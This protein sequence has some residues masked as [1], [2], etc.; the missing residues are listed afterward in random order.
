MRELTEKQMNKLKEHSKQ[1][2]GGMRGVHMRN[3]VKFMKEG[4]S[5][6]VA[7]NKAKK[8]DKERENKSNNKNNVKKNKTMKKNNY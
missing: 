5:F 8:L 3:M 6:T 2:K 1:H 4:M 7:H